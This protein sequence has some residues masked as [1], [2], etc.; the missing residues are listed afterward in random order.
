MGAGVGRAP[1]ILLLLIVGCAKSTD[2][3]DAD[4]P[5]WR[6]PS[7]V[8]IDSP[9]L[10]E[11]SAMTALFGTYDESARSSRYKSSDSALLSRIGII[12]TEENRS[13]QGEVKGP[14][15]LVSTVYLT[16]V[17]QPDAVGFLISTA[18]EG[19]E[20][21][22]DVPLQSYAFFKKKDNGWQ[23]EYLQHIEP[24]GSYGSPPGAEWIALRKNVQILRLCNGDLHMGYAWAICKFYLVDSKGLMRV[25]NLQ[26]ED[27]NEGAC[28]ENTACYRYTATYRFL[29]SAKAMPDIE[30]TESGTRADE[31][32]RVTPVSRKTIYRFDGIEYKPEPAPD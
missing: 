32:G 1:Y 4:L 20:A 25:F 24:I 18:F 28:D 5:D 12:A 31:K 29:P 14:A 15:V 7:Q 11:K 19:M 17:S 10:S 23:L 2:S 27:S 13:M 21:R 8:T 9:R 22:I 6:I 26:I 3:T 30:V 16:D